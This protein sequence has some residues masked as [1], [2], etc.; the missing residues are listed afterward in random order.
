[1]I[2]RSTSGKMNKLKYNFTRITNQKYKNEQRGIRRE[3]FI[4]EENI[5][6]QMSIDDIGTDT[7]TQHNIS[8]AQTS[9]TQERAYEYKQHIPENAQTR[10]DSTGR[11]DT[12]QQFAGMPKAAS[13]SDF[14]RNFSQE[15]R[16]N[17]GI[18]S[19]VENAARN[20]APEQSNDR[21]A[22]NK[23][24][25]HR[26][27]TN[28]SEYNGSLSDSCETEPA[29]A[30]ARHRHRKAQYSNIS[31]ISDMQMLTPDDIMQALRLSRST[32]YNMLKRGE[33]P[34]VKI[35]NMLRVNKSAFEHWLEQHTAEAH[36]V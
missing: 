23:T 33:I 30:G 28:D 26:A 10:S 32:V 24:L 16:N 1:M 35:G 13:H 25:E 36:E 12:T 2:V 31:P 8:S 29:T 21:T 17:S 9:P 4:M 22:E 11:N 19:N 3:E 7:N 5:R 27:V 18:T 20:A 34:S 6:G 15:H 14:R